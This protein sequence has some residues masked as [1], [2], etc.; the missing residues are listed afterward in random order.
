[1]F[2]AWTQLPRGARIPKTRRGY[3]LAK[4]EGNRQRDET[5]RAILKASGWRT[6][7]LWECELH[8][9]RY[10]TKKLRRFLTS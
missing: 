3:W 1:M 6:L 5:Y 10:I 2:L 7:T 8:D 9:V 4:I